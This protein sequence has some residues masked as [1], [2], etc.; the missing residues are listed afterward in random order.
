MTWRVISG[1][2]FSRS[3]TTSRS[4]GAEAIEFGV[5]SDPGTAS[6]SVIKRVPEAQLIRGTRRRSAGLQ[7]YRETERGRAVE[8]QAGRDIG[9]AL[10]K[11]GVAPLAALRLRAG[12]SQA[13][14]SE[15]TGLLQPHISRLE[16]GHPGSIT[17]ETLQKLAVGLGVS[18]EEI[19]GAFAMSRAKQ[20]SK[21]E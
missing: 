21:D 6:G 4:R 1:A 11:H 7:A 9:E 5:A 16:N 18:L 10:S 19:N 12:L 8:L 13:E 20:A 15:R 3:T 2:A 17:N 14:L